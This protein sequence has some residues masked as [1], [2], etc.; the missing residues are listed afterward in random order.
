MRGKVVK[1]Q[2]FKTN[3]GCLSNFTPV[4]YQART[5]KRLSVR[6][7]YDLLSLYEGRMN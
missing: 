3:E 6:L 7:M 4:L 5:W 2:F 1:S